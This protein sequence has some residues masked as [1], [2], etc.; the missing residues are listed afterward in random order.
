MSDYG[1]SGCLWADNNSRA[2]P[3]LTTQRLPCSTHHQTG[4]SEYRLL[5]DL[6]FHGGKK[7]KRE[8]REGMGEM[9]EGGGKMKPLS[10]AT[11]SLYGNH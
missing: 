2:Q 7:K 10:A 6:Y 4:I 9:G 3:V 1:A 11:G 5:L 8:G